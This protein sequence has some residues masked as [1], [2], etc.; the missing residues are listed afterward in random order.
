M[1]RISRGQESE[2]LRV[3]KSLG[4]SAGWGKWNEGGDAQLMPLV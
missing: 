3:I 1:W 4:Y 2:F